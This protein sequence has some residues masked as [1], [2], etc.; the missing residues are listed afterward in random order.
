MKRL[1]CTRKFKSVRCF[2]GRARN[3]AEAVMHLANVARE[4]HR[5]EQ[6]RQT[7][8]K[9]LR[10]IADRMV[11]IAD[12]ESRLAPLVRGESERAAEARK[13]TPP[14]APPPPAG[15]PAPLPAGLSEMTLQY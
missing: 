10:G 3:V 9:R 15:R 6:E 14:P 1:E 12:E 2:S 7:L 11:A 13:P 8:E 4:R 5:L